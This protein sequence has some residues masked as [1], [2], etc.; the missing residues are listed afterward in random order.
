VIRLAAATVRLDGVRIVDA[1]DL[2]VASGEWVM[3]I[4]R[5]GA[6]KTTLL[7]A[8]AGL[9]PYHGSVT[10]GG[11]EV[12]AHS[13]R[14]L[15]RSIAMVPQTPVVPADMTVADYVLLGRTPHLGFLARLGRHDRDAAGRALDSLHLTALAGR[16]LGSLSGGERQRCVLARALAQDASVLLLDEPTTALDVGR[17]QEVLELVGRLRADHELTVLGAI[18]DLT[19]AG[20]YADRLVLLDGGQVVASGTPREVLTEERVN[21]HYEAHVRVTHVEG[22]PVVLPVRPAG[23]RAAS[24]EVTG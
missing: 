8:V 24:T 20:Q 12:A 21:R 3:L 4:G 9:V 23:G 2:T 5:N 13:P 7:R 17:Q 18:H 22:F 6:G 11:R 15:A 10:V 19:L 1:A 14:Q 16:R